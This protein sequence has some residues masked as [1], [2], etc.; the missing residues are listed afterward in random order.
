MSNLSEMFIFCHTGERVS[1]HCDVG[2][3]SVNVGLVPS[4]MQSTTWVEDEAEKQSLIE[5]YRSNLKYVAT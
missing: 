2:I 4:Y 3:L 5:Q 1:S